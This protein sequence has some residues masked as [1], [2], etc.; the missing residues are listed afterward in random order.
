MTKGNEFTGMK[1][2]YI[3]EKREK[4][5]TA[6]AKAPSD[7]SAICKKA[8]YLEFGMPQFPS[9]KNKIYQKLWLLIGGFHNWTKLKNTIEKDSVIIY[10]HPMYGNRLMMKMIPMIKKAKHARFI[11]VVHDL[12]SLR[13]G[14][15]GV[16]QRSAKTNDIADNGLLKLFDAVICHNEHMR[17]YLIEQGVDPE[18]L[19]NLEIFDYL[20][21]EKMVS[22]EKGDEPSVA[23]AGNLSPGKCPYI[24]KIFDNENNP[25]LKVHLYGI[26]YQEDQTEKK[27]IYHGSFKPE[28]LPGKLTGDFGLVWDG[29]SAETCAGNTGYYLRFNNPHKTS[30]Y[31]SSGM[32]VIVWSQAAIADFVLEHGVGMTVDSLAELE[33]KI[34]NLSADDYKKMCEKAVEIGCKLRE[35]YFT[36]K[37]LKK[38]LEKLE[39]R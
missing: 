8:G 38:A 2:Y 33:T 7:I 27:L 35:G 23:I 13:G 21:D 26:N 31:L 39:T 22:H 19:I 3:S 28:E 15:A 25:D 37:A 30:L 10:Q 16:I 29:E 24:Y 18:K 17:G 6:G 5:S 9:K 14:I 4:R 36:S 20:S 32:P 12:E 34:K 11:A 1:V